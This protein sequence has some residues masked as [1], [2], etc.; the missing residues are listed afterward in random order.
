MQNYKSISQKQTKKL[1]L[2]L[3]E[4]REYPDEFDSTFFRLQLF[5]SFCVIFL[6]R[7]VSPTDQLASTAERRIGH[8][9]QTSGLRLSQEIEIC[10]DEKNFLITINSVVLFTGFHLL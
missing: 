4:V 9:H 8:D 2:M 3:H 5:V 1:D 7:F 6:D 10:L